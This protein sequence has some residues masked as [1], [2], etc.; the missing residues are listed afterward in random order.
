MLC[1]VF[2]NLRQHYN[3]QLILLLTYAMCVLP[4]TQFGLFGFCC[5]LSPYINCVLTVFSAYF[6][7]NGGSVN[8]GVFRDTKDDALRGMIAHALGISHVHTV[9]YNN[10]TV[11]CTASNLW[12]LYD[13]SD[14]ST[15]DSM[16]FQV[17]GTLFLGFGVGVD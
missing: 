17:V 6:T 13:K 8:V 2:I 14:A 15:R 3:S 16:T 1:V 10:L 5:F 4:C 9:V 11:E 7:G 12:Q